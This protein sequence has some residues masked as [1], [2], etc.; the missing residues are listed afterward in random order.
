MLTET[1]LRNHFSASGWCYADLSEAA[2]KMRKNKFVTVGFQYDFSESHAA[3][4]NVFSVKISAL[5]FLS[6][7]LEGFSKLVGNFKGVS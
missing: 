3:S 2:G 5:G 4:C 6:G 1:L 7:L